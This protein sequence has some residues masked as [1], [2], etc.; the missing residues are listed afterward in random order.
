[1]GDKGIILVSA[2]GGLTWAATPSGTEQKLSGIAYINSREGV[3]GGESGILLVTGDSGRTWIP[4][5]SP[6]RNHLRSL[7]CRTGTSI[8]AAGWNATILRREPSRTVEHQ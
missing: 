2:D 6:T 3:A 8:F 4:E 7:F 1:V 5:R